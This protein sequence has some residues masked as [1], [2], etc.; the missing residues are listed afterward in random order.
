VKVPCIITP[1][2]TKI[3]EMH[4]VD[5]LRDLNTMGFLP[6]DSLLSDK[7]DYPE[8]EEIQIRFK[9]KKYLEVDLPEEIWRPHTIHWVQALSL[10]NVLS[11]N[12]E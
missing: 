5:A 6:P 8:K 9:N 10:L 3:E 4:F 2:A 11:N 1:F 7:D 12:C